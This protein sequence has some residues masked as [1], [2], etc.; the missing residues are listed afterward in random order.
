MNFRYEIGQKFSLD[1]VRWDYQIVD[2]GLDR[3]KKPQYICRCI[4]STGKLLGKI[5]KSEFELTLL[6]P[7]TNESKRQE[8]EEKWKDEWD[9]A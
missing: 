8:A 2:R 9:G 1:G 6:F 4:Q 7:W 5:E 3:W